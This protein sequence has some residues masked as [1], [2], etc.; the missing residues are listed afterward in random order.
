MSSVNLTIIKVCVI[1]LFIA[2]TSIEIFLQIPLYLVAFL[3]VFIVGFIPAKSTL[4]NMDP[5]GGPGSRMTKLSYH[6]FNEW[7]RR[8]EQ[9]ERD[10]SIY[11]SPQFHWTE[12]MSLLAETSKASRH[13][14]EPARSQFIL[15]LTAL[16]LGFLTFSPSIRESLTGVLTFQGG[17]ANFYVFL[18]ISLGFI[19]GSAA[20]GFY[21]WARAML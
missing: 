19:A 18:G 14:A 13:R 6:Q 4:V 20:G 12:K 2:G 5:M 3:V 15:G 7:A 21:R 16:F 9:M 1:L 17:E 10:N 8:L 11:S